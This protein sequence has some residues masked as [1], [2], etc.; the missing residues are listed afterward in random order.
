VRQCALLRSLTNDVY[1]VSTTTGTYVLKVYTHARSFGDVAWEIELLAHLAAKGLTVPA[2]IK[3]VDGGVIG[4]LVAPEGT[5][6]AVL[7]SWAE[8]RKPA[9]PSAALYRA[10]GRLIARFH[11]AADDFSSEQPRLPFD[12]AGFLDPSLAVLLPHLAE[13]PDDR[14]FVAQL[15]ER[16][17]ERLAELAARGLDWGVCHGDVSLDNLHVT[18]DR[19]L[20]LFDFDSAGPGWRASDPY[21]VMTWLTRGKPEFWRAFLDGYLE[22]RPLGPADREALFWFVPVRLLDNLRWHLSDW[23][24]QRGTLA[25]DEDYLDGELAALRA[26]DQEVLRGMAAH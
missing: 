16:A 9:G 11:A 1:A 7:L 17:R 19:R 10:F 6:Y 21:G 12:V 2:T 25:L 24:L 26:W 5:R 4:T 14:A 22:F 20:V 8:G 3:R 23:L 15:A 18:D 13:R